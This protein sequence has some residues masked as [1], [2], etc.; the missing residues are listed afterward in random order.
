MKPS[1][2]YFSHIETDLRA[3]PSEILFY[4]DTADNVAAASA[5]GWRATW[6][7]DASD[8]IDVDRLDR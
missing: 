2:G 3:S 4:D 7:R 6:F 8:L 1:A 5:R